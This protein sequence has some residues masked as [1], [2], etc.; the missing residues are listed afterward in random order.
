MKKLSKEKQQQLILVVLVTVG[1]LAGLWLLLIKAQQENLRRL[2][3]KKAT[4]QQKLQQIRH[5]IATAD[6]VEQQLCEAQKVLAKD[7][8][9]MA[10]GDL[11]SWSITTLRTFKVGYKIEIPQYSQ[12]DGPK[13]VTL[14]PSFPYKQ[15]SLMVAGTASFHEF[16]RFVADFENQFP[17][18]RVLNVSLEPASAMAQTD[19][20][21]LSF[22]MEIAAL[23]KPG[24]S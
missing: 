24:A 22:R 11:Y 4:T 18:I 2:A 9:G 16:G 8:E 20:E 21:K 14:L 15:A 19:R 5:A 10:S 17:F 6:Q 7:E 12:I 1:V 13:D 3:E 23:V